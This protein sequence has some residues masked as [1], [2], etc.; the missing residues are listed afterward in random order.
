MKTNPDSVL[1]VGGDLKVDSH[2]SASENLIVSGN[3]F[4]DGILDAAVKNFKIDH[5]TMED[6]W[7]VHSSL[8]GPEIAMYVRGKLKTNNIIHLPDYWE[9]LT[10]D[11]DITVQ[12][13]PIG[14]SCQ[15]FV[16]HVSKQEIEVGCECGTPHCF[17]IVH[18]RRCDQEKLQVFQPKNYG[19]RI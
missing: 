10:D 9:E 18:A 1:H 11:V 7:L 19:P 15:H 17:Y 16:K 5:P 8:E 6:H 2:I 13:T 14:N 3:V 12:L 4:V